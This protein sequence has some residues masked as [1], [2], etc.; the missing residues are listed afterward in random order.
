MR[1]RRI[2]RVLLYP[3]AL[4][5]VIFLYSCESLLEP[6]S[7]EWLI[8]DEYLDGFIENLIVTDSRSVYITSSCPAIVYKYTDGVLS[9][10]LKDVNETTAFYDIDYAS[11]YIWVAAIK[12]N[13]DHADE[14]GPNRLSYLIRIEENGQF[15]EI[16]FAD[17]FQN[18][19]TFFEPILAGVN[20]CWVISENTLFK[21]DYLSDSWVKYTGIYPVFDIIRDENTSRLFVIDGAENSGDDMFV[22]ITDDDGASW[23]KE[24]V[25]IDSGIYELR[26]SLPVGDCLNGDLYFIV[27]IRYNDFEYERSLVRRL[28][29]SEPGSGEYE[30]AFLH[31]QGPYFFNP[32]LLVFNDE[33]GDGYYCGWQTAVYFDGT[34]WIKEKIAGGEISIFYDLAVGHDKYWAIVKPDSGP[35]SLAYRGF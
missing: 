7:P 30:I 25:N 1:S 14:G 13:P 12:D 2:T 6:V 20:N 9:T 16:G 22:W 31:P 5:V 15:R 23:V 24:P 28:S 19:N 33:R 26:H 4:F 8:I 35:I 3:F 29:G 11:G 21:Y 27:N 10:V 18:D 32:D 17:D 34:D